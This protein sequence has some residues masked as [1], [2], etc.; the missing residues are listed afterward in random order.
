M[1]NGVPVSSKIAWPSVETRQIVPFRPGNPEFDRIRCV[2][3]SN[4][5][6][7]L[8]NSFSIVGMDQLEER[9]AGA[10]EVAVID[11][12]KLVI[13]IRTRRFDPSRYPSPK[14]HLSRASIARRSRSSFSRSFSAATFSHFRSLPLRNI[15]E[16]Q[17]DALD[18]PSGITDRG[19]AVVDG[20][21]SA[22]STNRS[23]G[24]PIPRRCFPQRLDD[25]VFDGLAGLLHHKSK[26]LFERSARDVA[27][28]HSVR[29]FTTGFSNLDGSLR[30]RDD[31]RI[32]NAVEGDLEPFPLVLLR[33]TRVIQLIHL[34]DRSC[35]DR[36]K[37]NSKRLPRTIT[38]AV[39]RAHHH[40]QSLCSSSSRPSSCSISLTR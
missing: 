25:R 15:P 35:Q 18:R 4:S 38:R 29:T 21:L 13:P 19:R 8:R 37:E 10:L 5:A 17:N 28:F 3:S 33:L 11:P 2:L 12:V 32:P 20:N 40:E 6:I 22:V 36:D 7:A 34:E 31:N 9:L 27:C 24:W 30:I 39:S 23:C 16:D 14:C 1:R 26:Y